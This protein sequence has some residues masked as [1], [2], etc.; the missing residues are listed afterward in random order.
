MYHH[1]NHQSVLPAWE[2]QM[3]KKIEETK[4]DKKGTNLFN[5]KYN[6][7]ILRDE[8]EQQNAVDEPNPF[9]DDFNYD[10]WWNRYRAAWLKS[11]TMTDEKIKT[12]VD[13]AW[14]CSDYKE[15]IQLMAEMICR[16]QK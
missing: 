16:L 15:A 4:T 6:L 13:E 8:D 5:T 14:E 11:E 12:R 10:N 3:T 7:V 2:I 1:I 9:A